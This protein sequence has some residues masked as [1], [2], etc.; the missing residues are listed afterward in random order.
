MSAQLP[1]PYTD[2]CD[3]LGACKYGLSSKGA[4]SADSEAC[5]C[6]EG[7]VCPACERQASDDRKRLVRELDVALNGEACAAPQAS[8][9]DIVAQVKAE[10]RKR[11][12]PVLAKLEQQPVPSSATVDEEL[13][14][15]ILRYGNA[16][17]A[18][19]LNQGP[20]GEESAK[21]YTEIS[22]RFRPAHVVGVLEDIRQEIEDAQREPGRVRDAVGRTAGWSGRWLEQS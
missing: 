7:V 1:C 10:A 11:G 15:L 4:G 8:L 9:C 3:C 2:R 20:L 5:Y 13:D 22:C 19:G 18:E 14:T 12:V 17:Y 21:L 6:Q 16:C